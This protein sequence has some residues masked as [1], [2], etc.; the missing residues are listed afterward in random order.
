M[1]KA[2]YDYLTSLLKETNGNKTNAAEKAG[3]SRQGLLKILKDLN[4][5]LEKD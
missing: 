4:I 2:K 3:L 1:L 5:D